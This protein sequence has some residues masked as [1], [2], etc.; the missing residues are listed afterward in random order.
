M[1]VSSTFSPSARE[2]AR[3]RTGMRG[4]PVFA[5]NARLHPI[6]DPM[7]GLRGFRRIRQS[8]PDARLYMIYYTSE[9]KAQVLEAI[10]SDPNLDGAVELRGTIPPPAVEDFLNSA[11]FLIQCSL[12]EVAG[13]SVLEAV[14]TDIPSF[15]AMTDGGRFGVLFPAGDDRLLAERTLALA[16]GEIASRA[17]KLR[18]FFEQSLSYDSI[19]K[20]YE[21][22]L[23][24][25]HA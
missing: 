18:E 20:I 16:P 10:A 25:A 15:R 17:G 5:W 7:T 8:W 23:S 4:N 14:V 9:M 22:A 19:A 24:G 3:S 21:G 2:Q 12:Q 1:E 13:Y 6:K 11:D